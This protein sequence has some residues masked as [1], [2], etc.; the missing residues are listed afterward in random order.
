MAISFEA[1]PVFH[2]VEDEC[3]RTSWQ[4][5]YHDVTRWTPVT[6]VQEKWHAG[7]NN[8]G[9]SLRTRNRG[10]LALTHANFWAT[11][12][13]R[14]SPTQASCVQCVSNLCF[15]PNGVHFL[16]TSSLSS[17]LDDLCSIEDL[18]MGKAGK[19]V[20]ISVAARI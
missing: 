20:Y 5:Q 1:C 10:F 17:T 14:P 4:L 15:L 13:P 2:A 7:K 16:V 11:N 18:V 12:L 3:A 19:L 6:S 9:S 8:S